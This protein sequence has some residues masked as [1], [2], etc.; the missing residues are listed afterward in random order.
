MVTTDPC[1]SEI[2]CKA[3]GEF[4]KHG[5]DYVIFFDNA[6]WHLSKYCEK[7]YEEN[8]IQTI[9]NFPYSPILNAV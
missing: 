5:K 3:V 2:F 9:R 1:N 7:F 6:R 8:N 4:D